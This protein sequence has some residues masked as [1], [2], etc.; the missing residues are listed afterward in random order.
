MCS[1]FGLIDYDKKLTA[2]QK[3]RILN[4]LARECEVRGTDAT[5]IAYNFGGRMQIYK[6]PLPA[7]KLW[8]H[9]PNGV[10]VVMGHTRMT[11]QGSAK[12]NQNNHPFAGKADGKSFAL[13]HNGVLWNDKTLK[14]T[15]QLPKTSVETDSYVAV[16]LIEKQK[17]L[18]FDSLKTMA[19]TVE[20]SFVFTVLDSEDSIW[21]VVGDNPLCIFY[22]NGFLLYASTEK[23]LCNTASKLHLSAPVSVQHPEEGEILKIDR[24]GQLTTGSFTPQTSYLHWWRYRPYYGSFLLDEEEQKSVYGDLFDAAKSMGVSED[25]VQAL[26]DY[27]CDPDEIEELLY[28]PALLHEM[29]GELLYAY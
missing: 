1:L 19:E 10:N 29:T 8:L 5:G 17:A 9:V 24:S 7:H 21:F 28:D 20:G 23:I 16:Q 3:N 15:E 25:E 4:T 14:L 6:R 27:G 2:R 13:A 11:T 18:D 26:L 22:Y 12:H